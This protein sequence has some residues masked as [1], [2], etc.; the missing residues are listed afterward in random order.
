M[1]YRISGKANHVW[2]Q[3]NVEVQMLLNTHTHF[4]VSC[5]PPTSSIVTSLIK[6]GVLRAVWFR[7]SERS[8]STKR[9]SET[10][11]GKKRG[12]H[13]ERKRR[14]ER[15]RESHDVRFMLCCR[16]AGD[17]TPQTLSSYS[18]R[19]YMYYFWGYSFTRHHIYKNFQ[20]KSP[21]HII[22][23]RERFSFSFLV[24]VPKHENNKQSEQPGLCRLTNSL[25]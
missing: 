7:P 5:Y 18:T 22:F 6:D 3:H 21:G 25:R 4:S 11:R 9:G 14:R 19:Q 20:N 24:N 23:A 16:R 13:T 10:R 1:F 12:K 2:Q 15:R 17:P 8:Q